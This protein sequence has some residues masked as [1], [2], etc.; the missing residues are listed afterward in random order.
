MAI[1]GKNRSRSARS[2]ARGPKPAYVPVKRPLLRRRGVWIGAAVV[3]GIAAVVGLVY[4]F[5]KEREAQRASEERQAMAGAMRQY[6]GS[7]DGVLASVGQPEP[8]TG[9]RAFP[10]LAGAIEGLRGDAN[11]RDAASTAEGV[12]DG[13]AT[14]LEAVDAIDAIELVGNKGF[15]ADF[16]LHV[17]NSRQDVASALRLYRESALL[18]QLAAETP[19]AERADLLERAAGVLEVADATLARGYASYI[20]AQERAGTFRPP[21]PSAPG[22]PQAS[23]PTG[24]T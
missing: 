7:L 1:K 21:V 15:E 6:S 9:F 23:G 4:G 8:P 10:D 24:L 17:L 13:A 16:V 11:P 19:G 22:L 14:S 20:E 2:V 5:M 3:L 12:A 18:V